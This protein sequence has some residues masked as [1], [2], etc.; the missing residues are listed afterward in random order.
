MI[1]E[2][3]VATQLIIIT[4]V[5]ASLSIPNMHFINSGCM[6]RKNKNKTQDYY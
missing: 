1:V 5:I 2:E 4:G 6:K 3:I